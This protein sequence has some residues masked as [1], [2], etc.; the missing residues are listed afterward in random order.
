MLVHSSSI[1]EF[2]RLIAFPLAWWAMHTWLQHYLYRVTISWWA[3]VAAG[4]TAMLIA[5]LT[6]SFQAIKAAIAN[7]VKNLNAE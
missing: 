1:P 4:F 6:I 2:R 3:F 5:M 7:P